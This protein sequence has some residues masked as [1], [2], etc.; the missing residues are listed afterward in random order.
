MK[1]R[2]HPLGETNVT[3]ANVTKIRLK[4][5]M[6]QKDLLAKLQSEGM[7]ITGS[8]LSKIEGRT[9]MVTDKDL[10]IIAKALGVKPEDLL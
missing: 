2:K 10:L 4:K 3:G 1:P 8:C 5:D 7:E 6:K 9:K